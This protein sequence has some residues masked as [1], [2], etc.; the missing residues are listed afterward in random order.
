MTADL[1]QAK[2]FLSPGSD[3]GH[4]GGRDERP[5]DHNDLAEELRGEH[6]DLNAPK[7]E[8]AIEGEDP[9]GVEAG[10]ERVET[11]QWKQVD[12][13]RLIVV[14]RHR[15][16]E[17]TCDD[18][19]KAASAD[20]H[21]PRGVDERLVTSVVLNEARADANIAKELKAHQHDLNEAHDAEGLW[22]E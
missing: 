8:V 18:V 14:G 19:E 13:R 15:V 9:R 5:S 12:E 10:G 3:E 17:G 4:D 20:L 2:R 1:S 22:E 7:G 21:R 6:H 11:H 16:R